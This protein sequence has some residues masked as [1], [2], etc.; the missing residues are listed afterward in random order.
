M[1]F[2]K[3]YSKIISMGIFGE[4]LTVRILNDFKIE[5]KLLNKIKNLVK[6]LHYIY[7]QIYF[8]EKTK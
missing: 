4:E 2:K 8:K 3:R 6:N 7:L 5:D 1:I